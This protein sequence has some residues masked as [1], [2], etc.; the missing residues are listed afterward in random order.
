MYHGGDGDG[1]SIILFLILAA[2]IGA[3]IWI[4]FTSPD[5]K[6]GDAPAVPKRSWDEINDQF[7]TSIK[8][9]Q[10]RNDFAA[11][12]ALI[13]LQNRVKALF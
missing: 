12:G 4:I 3:I 6:A 13:Q 10:A 11:V 9:A 2:I 5:P 7:E 1:V 8:E